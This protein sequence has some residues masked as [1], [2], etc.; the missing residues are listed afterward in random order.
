MTSASV[1][2]LVG[3]ESSSWSVGAETMDRNFTLYSEWSQYLGPLGV[4][5][6]R[7]QAGSVTVDTSGISNA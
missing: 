2:V 7:V 1:S 6:A 4:K 5:R 3:T